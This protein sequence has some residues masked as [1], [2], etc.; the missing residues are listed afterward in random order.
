M[1]RVGNLFPITVQQIMA[2]QM[3]EAA[4]PMAS[5]TA[6]Y[7]QHQQTAR[8]RSPCVRAFPRYTLQRD[9]AEP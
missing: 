3:G 5:R 6:P 8:I 2:K 7:Q 1:K 9:H 4:V